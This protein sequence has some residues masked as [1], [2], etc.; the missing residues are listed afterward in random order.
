MPKK[1]YGNPN[2]AYNNYNFNE[3]FYRKLQK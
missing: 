2:N 3:M 1:L